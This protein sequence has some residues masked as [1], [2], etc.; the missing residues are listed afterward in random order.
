MSRSIWSVFLVPF[1][2]QLSLGDATLSTQVGLDDNKATSPST[3]RRA[4]KVSTR[5]YTRTSS[6]KLRNQQRLRTTI[7]QLEECKWLWGRQKTTWSTMTKDGPAVNFVVHTFMR[8]VATPTDGNLLP[9]KCKGIN[10]PTL[11][12]ARAHLPTSEGDLTLAHKAWEKLQ[13]EILLG[14]V[15]PSPPVSTGDRGRIL[16]VDTCGVCERHCGADWKV[17]MN[18]TSGAIVSQ[19]SHGCRLSFNTMVIRIFVKLLRWRDT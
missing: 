7:D 18:N 4:H 12:H 15:G 3:L 14:R 9:R 2:G 17:R 6:V 8:K 11:A 1:N 13:Q 19:S 10:K 5:D 16:L